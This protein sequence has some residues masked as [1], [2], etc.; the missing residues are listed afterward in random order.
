M[1]LAL[2]AILV[3][4]TG[5]A[6]ARSTRHAAHHHKAVAGKSH[7]TAASTTTKSA[8][9]KSAATKS[10]SSKKSSTGGSKGS[11]GKGK[12][13]TKGSKTKGT[14]G[15]G[16]KGSIGGSTGGSGGATGGSEGS[17]GGSEGTTE[18]GSGGSEGST[19]GSEGSTGG[20]EGSTEGSEGSTE[21]S[22][23]GSGGSTGGSTGA[24]QWVM[25]QH[26]TWYWQIQG[27]VNNSEP[28]AAYDIDG[29]ENTAAEVAALHAKNIHVIC[30]MDVGTS[31]NYRSDFSSFPA[32]VQGSS[33][34]WP[35][36]KWLD[37]RQLSVLE[38]IMIKRFEMCKEKGF[39]AVEPD[40]MDGY[41]N[42]TGFPI[43]AAQQ[44]TYDEWVATEVH[45]LGMAVLQKND[46]E[47]TAT[48]EP[49]FDGALDEQCNQ[50]SECSNFQAYLK[51]GKPVLNAEYGLAA[52]AFCA[53]DNAAGIMGARYD[54]ELDG[55]TFEPCW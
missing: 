13:K 2:L 33:N 52:S 27:A 45:S 17:T 35:G 16:S 32:A 4:S 38:P 44:A 7:G 49:H 48:L 30:Y 54:L 15:K 43:T 39:D 42:S 28:V 18:G 51:A 6:A 24:G 9:T 3:F 23:G 53:A 14:K 5:A 25:P 40:N 21:G 55:K 12:G 41:E 31:E 8:T 47:Q 37:V 26:L 20:S 50:Y 46:G 34:G 29:F 19:G 22:T 11:K 1:P 36:E 10:G